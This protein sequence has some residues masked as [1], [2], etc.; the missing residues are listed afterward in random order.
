MNK[1][2]RPPGE[3][4]GLGIRSVREYYRQRQVQ[5]PVGVPEPIYVQVLRKHPTPLAQKCL[6]NEYRRLAAR[7]R[8][9]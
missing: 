3:M 2:G 6:R 9:A 7:F 5:I 8:R 1:G 4:P